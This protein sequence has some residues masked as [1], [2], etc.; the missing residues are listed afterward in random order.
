MFTI[1]PLPEFTAWLDGV[2]DGTVRGVVVARLKRLERGLI[3]DVESVGENVSEL[4]IH[5]G[6]GWRVYYTLRGTQV[7]VLLVGGSKRTQKRDIK[8][9]KTLAALLD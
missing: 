6:A 5:I 4:R 3:G 8:R 1:K 2:T 7:I 9:A